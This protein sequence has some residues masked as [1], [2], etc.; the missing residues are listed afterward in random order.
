MTVADW[1]GS[2]R[3]RFSSDLVGSPDCEAG[4]GFDEKRELKRFLHES[5]RC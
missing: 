4:W 2:S 5:Q 1:V 3:I